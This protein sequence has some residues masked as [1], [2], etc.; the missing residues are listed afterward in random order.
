MKEQSCPNCGGVDPQVLNVGEF[1]CRFCGTLFHDKELQQQHIRQ[2][3]Q[4]AQLYN[5]NLREQ[6]KL[7]QAKAIKSTGRRVLLFV[8]VI[9][10]AVFGLVAYFTNKAMEE[11][12]KLEEEILN[13]QKEMQEEIMKSFEK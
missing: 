6:A 1:Q 8:G 2:Q 7:Q 12:R 5:Q 4:Q 10:V 13:Q 9:L 3:Q 11:Q